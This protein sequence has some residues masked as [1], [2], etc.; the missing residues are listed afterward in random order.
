MSFQNSLLE[1]PRVHDLFVEGANSGH[2]SFQSLNDLLTDL[3]TD[4][5]LQ[6]DEDAL[7]ILFD[8]LDARDIQVV[9]GEAKN[10]DEPSRRVGSTRSGSTPAAHGKNADLDDVL[11][12]LQ[13]LESH[14]LATGLPFTPEERSGRQFEDEEAQSDIA[15]EDAFKQYLNRMGQ[16]PLLSAE[17]EHRL[18][19]RSKNGTPEEQVAAKQKLVESNLRLVVSIAKNYNARTPLPMMDLVQEGNIGLMRAV[20]KFD[21][22]RGHRLS[23]Y[24][25]WWI[26]QRINRAIS[27]QA[28]SMRLPGHLYGAIQKIHRVQRELSQDLGRAPL[29]E[30]VAE[31]AGMTMLQ[32][33]EIL[34][35]AL[36]PLSLETPV[37]EDENE[38]LGE[39]LPDENDDDAPVE[40]LSRSELKRDLATAMQRLGERERAILEMRF[41][42]GDYEDSGAQTLEDIARTL[43]LSRERVRQLEVRALRKLRRRAHG[44]ALENFFGEEE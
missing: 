19:V 41:G 18:A 6:V 39:V 2:V 3:Q 24:A 44:T 38:E 35:A 40:A 5:S 34:R 20:D 30:E 22:A 7:E 11:S 9:E 29:R 16:V 25:T 26:R 27:D 10:K 36:S 42:L 28:R 33:D 13:D 43:Q 21:P 17:E 15:V 37:G 32:V 8:A 14:L 4:A 12:S 31:A 1:H 23:T